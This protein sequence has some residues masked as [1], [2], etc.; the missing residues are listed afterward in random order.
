M[1]HKRLLIRLLGLWLGVALAMTTAGCDRKTAAA[2]DAAAACIDARPDSALA[3]IRAIDTTRLGSRALRARYALLHAIALDKNWIDTTDVGVVMPAVAYYERH[4]PLTARAK[5]WYYLGRIQ[6]NGRNYDEAIISFIRAKEYAENL[7]DNRFKA[8]ICQA[9][10]DTYN[11]SYLFEEALTFSQKAYEYCCIDRDTLLANAVLYNIARQNNNLQKYHEADSI[12]KVLLK[13]NSI[14]PNTRPAILA[15]YALLTIVYKKDYQTALNYFEESLSLKKSLPS[16]QHWLAY[17]YCLHAIGS[18]EKSNTILQMLEKPEHDNDYILLV[19]KSRILERERDFQTA[20][21]LLESASVEQAK[22]LRLVLGQS[23][24]K[25]QRDYFT[26]QNETLKK[27]NRLRKW[28]NLLLAF[29]ILA[30]AVTAVVLIRRYSENV[31]RKNLQLMETAQELVEQREAV[32]ALSAE[33]RDISSRQ[34]QLRQ[35][36][37]HLSQESFKQL[38][39][40]CNTYYKTEGKPSQIHSVYGEVRGL[41]KTIGISEEQYP[42]F[43]KRV[44][45]AFDHVMEHFRAEHP[46]HRETYFQTACYLFAGFKTRTIAILL[47]R[48]EKDIYQARWRLK[49]EVESTPT[50]H[51]ND[52][53]TL[54]DGPEK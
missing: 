26:L 54:L 36:F 43:E 42:A 34:I 13:N 40:L 38:S 11:S 1:R 41:L 25:A 4:K 8:L 2:L 20:Y 45:D 39:D 16:R 53:K 33:N 51:Q 52:F 17:S 5:P 18:Y 44:N 9:I 23:A 12:Y 28:V 37:F 29:S 14:H 15:D 22:N 47:H 24:I 31:R 46:D 50:L 30:S 7:K 10:A 27:E 6:Y 35:D 49:K 48:D 32:G 19:W 21:R 3:I